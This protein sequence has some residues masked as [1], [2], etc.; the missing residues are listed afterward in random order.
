MVNTKSTTTAYLL[1]FFLGGLSA[2]RFY[3][4]QV[5]IG[6]LYLFTL[7]LFGIGWIIDAFILS[8][9]VDKYNLMQGLKFGNNTNTQHVT[10]NM[11]AP[12]KEEV[13]PTV[14]K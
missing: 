13:K 7:Q 11:A 6:L 14:E 9:M 4:G 1:W 5:G 8:G 3:L 2:H 12:T 10:V